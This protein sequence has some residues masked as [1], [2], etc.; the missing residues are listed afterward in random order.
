V[1]TRYHLDPSLDPGSLSLGTYG[2]RNMQFTIPPALSSFQTRHSFNDSLGMD[3]DVF[4]AL[5]G[6]SLVWT[7][8]TI[9]PQTGWPVTDP[10]GGFLPINDSTGKGTGYVTFTVSPK[11]GVAT[12]TRINAQALI[13][14]DSNTP[15]ATQTKFNTVDGFAPMSHVGTLGDS[16]STGFDVRWSGSDDAG[17]ASYTVYVSNNG[18]DFQP[19]VSSVADTVGRFSGTLGSSY[20]FYSVAVDTAGNVERSK[21]TS[22]ASTRVVTGVT[23]AVELPVTYNLFQNYPNPFN[24]SSTIRIALPEA[25]NVTLVVYNILGQRVRTLV[26][27]RMIAGYQNIHFDG[28]GCASGVYFYHLRAGTFVASR[29]MLL[30][31]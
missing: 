4:A 21:L 20:G 19:W 17:I 1:R 27:E 5:N 26:D 2:F 3:V 25:A 6:D 30:V 29:K 15:L 24:P 31:K 14:F 16:S 8:E 11:A 9:N 12:G 18:I 23:S 10:M 13:V 22:E 28:S 7:F